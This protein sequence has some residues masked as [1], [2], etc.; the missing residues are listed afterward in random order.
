MIHVD[1][2]DFKEHKTPVGFALSLGCTEELF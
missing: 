1:S 2:G